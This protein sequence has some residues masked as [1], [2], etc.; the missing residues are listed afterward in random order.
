MTLST[1]PAIVWVV[2]N[3]NL[4]LE[5]VPVGGLQPHL[6]KRESYLGSTA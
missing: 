3:E 4:F 2:Q 6:V 5:S 1:V